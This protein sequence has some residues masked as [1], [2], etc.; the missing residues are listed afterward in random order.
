M[1]CRL[2]AYTECMVSFFPPDQDQQPSFSCAD[3]GIYASVRG[4]ALVSLI[5]VQAQR[6]AVKGHEVTAANFDINPDQH[7]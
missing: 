2:R 5:R 6:C 7:T 4:E 1:Y 3:C